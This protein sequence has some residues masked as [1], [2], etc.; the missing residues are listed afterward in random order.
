MDNI[1][2]ITTSLEEVCARLSKLRLASGVDADTSRLIEAVLADPAAHRALLAR[3]SDLAVDD[4]GFRDMFISRARKLD[5]RLYYES[6][7][8]YPSLVDQDE[9]IADDVASNESSSDENSV[10]RDSAGGESVDEF[11]SG[12]E[13]S[14]EEYERADEEWGFR[15]MLEDSQRILEDLK[16]EREVAGESSLDDLLG[17]SVAP[18]KKRARLNEETPLEAVKAELEAVESMIEDY[19]TLAEN[20]E[21]AASTLDALVDEFV[22][23]GGSELLPRGKWVE[24]AE[25]LLGKF[26]DNE[27]RVELGELLAT[28]GELRAQ[29]DAVTKDD[30]VLKRKRDEFEALEEILAEQRNTEAIIDRAA[31]ANLAR[32]LAQDFDYRECGPTGVKLDE[33]AIDAL[34]A[35][36]EDYLIRLFAGAGD[37][38]IHS[39]RTY[40]DPGD[41]QFVRRIQGENIRSL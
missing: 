3:I 2:A 34:Q 19:E 18:T 21:A 40:L 12:A 25:D 35:A 24:N 8:G 17:F 15:L 31:F 38:A 13:D 30:P 23:P 16:Y 28:I 39:K 6:D 36:A 14:D 11:P 7:D 41:T 10:D 22:L 33:E 26:E 5:D 37:A 20:K 9:S 29:L 32:E 1:Y 4:P 27:N